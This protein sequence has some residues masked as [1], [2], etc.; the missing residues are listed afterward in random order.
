MVQPEEIDAHKKD[1]VSI[2]EKETKIISELENLNFGLNDARQTV[3]LIRKDIL[4]IDQLINENTRRSRA[5]SKKIIINEKYA[6]QRIVALYK[7]NQLGKFNLLAST[8]SIYD[9]FHRKIA[10]EKILHQ[11]EIVFEILQKNQDELSLVRRNLDA[12]KKKKNALEK[13]LNAQIQELTQKRQKRAQLLNKIRSKKALTLAAIKSLKRS[14]EALDTTFSDFKKENPGKHPYADSSP[15]AFTDLKGLL[16]MPVNG[17]IVE[18]FGAY[19]NTEFNLVNFRSGINIRAERGEPILA[20]YK[21]RTLY[22]SWFKGYG[23]MIIIDHG[24]HYYTLYAHAEE[25]FKKK[26]D[27]VEAGEVIA[28]VGDTGSMAKPGLHFEVR[29]HGKPIDPAPWIN[30]G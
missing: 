1:I 4:K 26:G 19:T 5:F 9:L 25:I 3:F 23:N 21:G 12:Q 30:K 10:L 7:L 22:A 8:D 2:T 18:L 15:H 28:T 6:S 24:D 29:Y 13:R 16:I 14:A 17:K 27:P 20:V 11:D